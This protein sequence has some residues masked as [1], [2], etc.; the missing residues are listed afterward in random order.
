MSFSVGIVGLPNVGK[1]TLFK[2]LTKN[3]VEIAPYPFTTIDPNVGRVAVPDKELE[4][5]AKTINPEK[6]T[7][8]IIE[9][10]DIAGLVKNAHKGEGL[11]NQFLAQIRNCDAILEVIRVFQTKI[12]YEI[13]PE[14]DAEI[15]KNELI[16]KDLE[17]ID[18]LLD[19][20]RIESLRIIKEKLLNRED[21][22]EE[23][24]K[25]VKDYQLLSIKPLIRILNGKDIDLKEEEEF[26]ELSEKERK[27][28]DFQSGLDKI[29]V[30]CYN[31]LDLITFYTLK[32]SKELRAWTL[33]KGNN[34]QEAASKV[35]SDFKEKFIRAEV[36]PAKKLIEANSWTQAKNL[37]LIK[38]VGKEYIVQ[39]KDI[40]EF[41]I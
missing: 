13:N 22:S 21:L 41:K 26:S 16:N 10:I 38:T 6:T 25:Q 17:T 23:E 32:G 5:I 19:K 37:G 18:K 8:T 4:E 40:I 29:I 36:I 20:E 24:R 30:S 3:P 2:A 28:L 27:D 34:C 33:Q 7:P 9:F 1:S 39:D 11:G 31:L 14:R 15:I 12:E 35:H